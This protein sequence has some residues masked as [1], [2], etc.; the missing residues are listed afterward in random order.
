MTAT[1]GSPAGAERCYPAGVTRGG[2]ARRA[3]GEAPRLGDPVPAATGAVR[4]RFAARADARRWRALQQGIYDEGC[5]FVGDGPASETALASRLQFT[6][7]QRGAVWLAEHDGLAV[8]WCEASR[9]LAERLEHVALI[10]VAVMAGHRRLGIGRAL[11]LEAE[12]WARSLRLRKL[13]LH[14]RAGNQAAVA[15]YASLGYEVEGVE[16]GQVR[17]GSHY[18]DN[19]VMAKHLVPPEAP[20]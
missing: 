3:A 14:V 10:T 15:L 7:R 2:A 13:T 20:A 17:H 4:V 9:P 16:R 12:T 5:F 11:M 6:P 19:L 8:G 1:V 18:E